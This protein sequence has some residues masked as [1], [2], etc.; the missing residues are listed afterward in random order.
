MSVLPFA[1]K[2]Q[3]TEPPTQK[4]DVGFALGFL[5]VVAQSRIQFDFLG[6]AAGSGTGNVGNPER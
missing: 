6:D 4:H 5:S 2:W 1:W 3:Q